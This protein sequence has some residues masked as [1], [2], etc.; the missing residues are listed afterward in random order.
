[1]QLGGSDQW[2][3]I[4]SGIELIRRCHDSLPS[5]TSS[6]EEKDSGREVFG[7]TLPLLTT[8]SGAKFGKSA[9][10]AVWLDKDL[11]SYFDLYQ[12]GFVFIDGSGN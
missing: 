7:L 5:Q 4:V 6:L 12:V 3:N 11:T 9:G 2:G 1:M 10:N 8:S